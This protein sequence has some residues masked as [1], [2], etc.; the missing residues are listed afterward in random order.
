M[1]GAFVVAVLS[2]A[3]SATAAL[4][5]VAD[6]AAKKPLD[7]STPHVSSTK[8]HSAAKGTTP[9]FAK[10]ELGEMQLKDGGTLSLQ[11]SRKTKDAVQEA[12]GFDQNPG[13]TEFRSLAP[14]QKSGTPPYVGF[15]LSTPTN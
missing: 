1:R 12:T 10:S 14:A 13:S 8:T 5:Q 2:V 15:K 3:F 11:G 9:H 7:L 4:A 6:K